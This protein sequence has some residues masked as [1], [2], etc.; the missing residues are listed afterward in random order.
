[1]LNADLAT[2]FRAGIPL[3]FATTQDELLLGIQLLLC[4]T[5]AL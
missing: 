3:P 4:S 5:D 1:M 2:D